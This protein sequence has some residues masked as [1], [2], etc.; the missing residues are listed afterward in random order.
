MRAINFVLRL[1]FTIVLLYL[2]VG[3]LLDAYYEIVIYPDRLAPLFDTLSDG[4]LK[5][6]AGASEGLDKIF[7]GLRKGMEAVGY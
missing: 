4:V 3:T 5:L 6:H 1:L 2:I 7:H